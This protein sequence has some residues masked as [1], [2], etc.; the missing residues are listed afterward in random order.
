M[1]KDSRKNIISRNQYL[2]NLIKLNQVYYP[3]SIEEREKITQITNMLKKT[4]G[5]IEYFQTYYTIAINQ[6]PSIQAIQLHKTFY[7]KENQTLN[8]KIKS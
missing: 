7:S 8:Q 4:D 1:E 2:T 3:N 6:I 5:V